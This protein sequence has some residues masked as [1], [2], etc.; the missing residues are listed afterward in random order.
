VNRRSPAGQPA[1]ADQISH[2]EVWSAIR[3]LDP[4]S[5]RGFSDMIAVMVLCWTVLVSCAIYLAVHLRH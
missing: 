5:Q 1:N 2:R 4:D 3:Y